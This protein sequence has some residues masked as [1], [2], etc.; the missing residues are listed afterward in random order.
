MKYIG[1]V[2]EEGEEDGRAYMIL[3]YTEFFRLPSEEKD[4]I[5]ERAKLEAE[6]RKWFFQN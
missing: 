1:E 3:D 4:K 2:V 6:T 5:V